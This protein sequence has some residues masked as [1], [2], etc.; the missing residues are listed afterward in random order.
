M[1]EKIFIRPPQ[2][3][4]PAGPKTKQP[5]GKAVAN[6][7]P[8]GPNFDNV[9]KETLAGQTAFAGQ[10]AIEQPAYGGDL[11]FSAH[12]LKRLEMRH[13]K[14]GAE[15]LAQIKAAV[16]KAEAKGARESLI[17]MDRLALVVSVKNRTV[18]TAV[19]NNN[20]KDNVFTNIDSAIIVR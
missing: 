6:H 7:A 10:T 11:K 2:I 18:I 16:G 9:L 15:D 12:A 13:I 20:L 4:G 3:G 19:D 17:L 8:L 1:S 14:L 5:A